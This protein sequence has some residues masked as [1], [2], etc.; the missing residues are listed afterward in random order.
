L[1]QLPKESAY[2]VCAYANNQWKLDGEIQKDPSQTSFRKAMA[3]S[4]GTVSIV[5]QR[6]V[7]YSRI[8]C[9]YEVATTLESTGQKLYDISTVLPDSDRAVVLTDGLSAVDEEEGR[10][11]KWAHRGGGYCHK[12]DRERAFPVSVFNK[13]FGVQLEKGQ[14]SQEQDRVRILNSIAG[15]DLDAPPL[16]EHGNYSAVND[17]LRWRFGMGIISLADELNLMDDYKLLDMPEPKGQGEVCLRV[18]DEM[19]KT[20]SAVAKHDLALS[21]VQRML[22]IQLELGADETLDIAS[23]YERMGD[24]QLYKGEK[25][26]ALEHQEKALAIREKLLSGEDVA[27]ARSLQRVGKL[28]HKKGEN[29][30]AMELYKKALAMQM[31]VVGQE[32]REAAT[33][34]CAMGSI[35]LSDDKVEMALQ[36]QKQALEMRQKILGDDHPETAESY[37]CMAQVQVKKDAD[38]A[39]KMFEKSLNIRMKTLGENHPDVAASYEKMAWCCRVRKHYDKEA[40]NWENKCLAVRLALYG[41]VHPDIA[42]SYHN[43]ALTYIRIYKHKTLTSNPVSREAHDYYHR[44]L[45]IEIQLYGEN[46]RQVGSTYEDLGELWAPQSGFIGQHESRSSRKA[47]DNYEKAARVF[48]ECLGKDNARTQRAW[49]HCEGW[50]NSRH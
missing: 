16:A 10:L 33:L 23:S 31:K 44:A 3:L 39:Q 7:T 11:V 4:D 36:C 50:R 13:A 12:L 8:W 47:A 19:Y 25:D 14:A 42:R 26:I 30:K 27:V 17:S 45:K 29:E 15:R 20:L 28:H 34:Y 32:S 18:Y 43:I 35:H 37:F 1:R 40:L 41:D 22:T 5:D 49:A 2:W 38:K 9:S 24:I 48:E 6:A 46:S 21:M